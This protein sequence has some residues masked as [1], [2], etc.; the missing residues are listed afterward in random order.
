MFP[1]KLNAAFARPFHL[2]LE[3][4]LIKK[5]SARWFC[6]HGQPFSL[7][8]NDSIRALIRHTPKNAPTM[9]QANMTTAAAQRGQ[10]ASV[11]KVQNIGVAVSTTKHNTRRSK[12]GIA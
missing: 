11:R 6:Q 12:A 5:R 8:E 3:L 2:K 9:T 4:A 7:R 10:P 1:K